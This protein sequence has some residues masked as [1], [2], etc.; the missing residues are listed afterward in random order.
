MIGIPTPAEIERHPTT[1][2]D[3]SPQLLASCHHQQKRR[4]VAPEE[5]GAGGW[6]N[7]TIV[8]IFEHLLCLEPILSSDNGMWVLT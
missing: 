7:L 6:E 3:P 2:L 8:E 1:L 5:K 4:P